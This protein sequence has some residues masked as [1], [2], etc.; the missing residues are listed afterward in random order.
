MKW[1]WRHKPKPAIEAQFVVDMARAE[2]REVIT[3]MANLVIQLDAATERVD[4][5]VAKLKKVAE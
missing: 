2:T 4:A 5:A 1:W 3:Q